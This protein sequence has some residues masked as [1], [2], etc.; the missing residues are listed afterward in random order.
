[1]TPCKKGDENIVFPP[2]QEYGPGLVK[3]YPVLE[4]MNSC[5]ILEK[6]KA[7]FES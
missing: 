1:M 7:E 3:L 5:K 4:A 6:V 2:R